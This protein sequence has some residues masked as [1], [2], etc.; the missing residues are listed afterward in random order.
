MFKKLHLKLTLYMGI[1][2]CLFMVMVT[3]GI[4]TFTKYVYEEQTKTLMHDEIAKIRT[5]EVE[6]NMMEEE[7]K[8]YVSDDFKFK[9]IS[10]ARN[11]DCEFVYYDKYMNTVKEH[12][13]NYDVAFQARKL[14]SV[15]FESKKSIYAVR[16]I[17][18]VDYRILTEFFIENNQ[19][20]VIQVFQN[21]GEE[22]Y[23]WNFLKSILSVIGF[24]GIIALIIISYFFTGK[25]IKPIKDTWKKQK[26]FVADASHE[27]RTPLT[28]IRTNLEVMKEDEEGNIEDNMMW[29][30]NAFTET[31]VMSG[32]IDQML[33]LAKVDSNQTVIEYMEVSLSEVVE[34]ICD[35]MKLIAEGKNI[36]LETYIES[37]II[38]QAD[39]DK[40]RRLFVILIDNAIKYTEEGFI[41]VKLYSDKGKIIFSVEDSGIGISEEDLPRI[42]D[43]FYR[44]DKARNRKLGGTGLGLSIAKWIANEHKACICVESK[45]GKGSKFKVK[46]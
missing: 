7:F 26:E 28:V 30:D 8:S 12:I 21:T 32:L 40:I 9:I 16:K 5:V 3:S 10:Y 15:A 14:A 37:G 46:F 34:N 45:Y 1:L 6:S 19:P 33:T 41:E 44:S 31:Q 25:A 20:F 29:L 4:Y 36:S 22:M 13:D 18:N 11:L 39:Y 35:N 43:R 27:L 17:D 38:I 2:L 23:I 42:F 24:F